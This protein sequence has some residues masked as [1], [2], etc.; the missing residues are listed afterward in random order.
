MQSPKVRLRRWLMASL[1]VV[2]LI[3]ILAAPAQALIRPWNGQPISQG[4]G[5]TYGEAWPISP[6]DAGESAIASRQSAPLALMPYADIKA[7]LDQFKAEAAAAGVPSRM[8]YEVLGQSA[9][10][11]DIY[12]VVINAMETPDQVRD[13]NRWK[14]IRS[15]MLTSPAEAQELLAT[16]GNDVKMCAYQSHIHGNEYEAVDSNMQVIRDLTVTPRG[17]NPTVDKI[18]DNEIVVV[19]MDNNPDGR[20]NGTRGNPTGLDPNRDFFVQSQPEQ[21]IAVA[22]MHRWLPT[23]FIEGHGYYTPTLID[24]VTIPHNP[25]IEED[26]YQ[27]WNV[28]R[29]EQNRADFAADG[30]PGLT[31]IQSPIRDWN[32]TGGTSTRNYLV[33][34]APYT[35]AAGP[36]TIA[37]TSNGGASE[38]G[39]IVTITTSSAHNLAVG[40]TVTITGVGVA[41]YNGTWT[42]A[43]IVSSTKFT[44]TNP[45]SALAASGS[46]TVTPAILGAS[47]AGTTVTINTTTAN[48]LAVGNTVTI[49]GVSVAG[50]NGTWTVASIVS[51]TQFTYTNPTSGLANSGGGSVT[52][53]SVAPTATG[54]TESGNTVTIT[55]TASN[56][57]AQGYKVVISGVPEA[58]Y[59]GTFQVTSVIS[60]TQF[61][62]T[63]PTSGL[64]DS[65][66]G[67]VALPPQPN[68]AQSWDDWGPFYGQSY[69]ALLGG[70]DGSTVEMT[71][72][73][74]L[75]SKQAQYLAFYSSNSFWV[76]HKAAMMH[77]HLGNFIRGAVNAGPNPTAFD[78]DPVLSSRYYSDV[79]QNY[80]VPYPKAYIIP[81]ELLQRSDSEANNLVEWLLRNGILVTRASADFAWGGKT[82]QAGSYVVWMNQPLRGIAWNALSAG[83]DISGTKITT[84]YASPGAW[85]HGLCWGADV[86]EVPRGDDT[87][88]PATVLTSSPSTL[89]GGIRDGVA[90]PSDWYSVTLKGVHEYPAI[91]GLLKSGIDAQMAETQFVSTTAGTMP[92]GTLIFPASAKQAL[93]EAGQDGGLWFERNVGVTMPPTTKVSKVPRIAVLVT[94]TPTGQSETSCV[95]DSIFSYDLTGKQ[96]SVHRLVLES[97]WDYVA[98]QESTG[99]KGLN[100]SSISDPLADYDVIYTTLTAWPT[101]AY[102]VARQRLADFFA[103]GGGFM[104]QNVSSAGFLTGATPSA[105]VTGTLTRGS[106]S[107]YGGIALVNNVGSMT[108]PITGPEPSLDTLFLPSTVYWYSAMPD[109]AVVDQQYPSTIATIGTAN[110]FVAGLWNGRSSAANNGPVLFHG[111][112][113]QGSRYMFYN[114]NAFSR[115]DGQREWLYFV[116]AALWSNLTD[117]VSRDGGP[118]SQSVQYGGSD[119]IQPVSFSAGDANASGSAMSV[120]A[121]DLP[122]G[123][124]VTQTSN[125]GSTTPGAASWTVT[126]NVTAPV[127]S[128][129]VTLTVTDGGARPVGTLKL[130]FTVDP[131]EITVNATGHDK[132]YDGSLDA[133]VDLAGVGLVSGDEVTFQYTAAT[134]D[135][136]DVGSDIPVVVQ[137]I[138]IHGADAGNYQL[139][140]DTAEARGSISPAALAITAGD[141]SKLFGVT[142]AFAG[143]EFTADGLVVGEAIDTVILTCDGSDAA[144]APGTY[145]IVPSAAQPHAGTTLGNYAV[146]YVNGTMTVTGGYQIAPFAKPL[147]QTDPRRFHRGSTIRVAFKVKD[148]DGKLVTT[149]GPT[150]Q[151]TRGG[152]VVL[153]PKTVKYNQTKKMYVYDVR[154]AKSWKLASYS[155]KVTLAGSLGRTVSFKLIK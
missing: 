4:L 23:A 120:S 76:D 66:G 10:G 85:S 22:Y 46:G 45:T 90:A 116:Q 7:L 149:V 129:P 97:D 106:G 72:S 51:S 105:L 136:A 1:F 113:T 110:G 13:F 25:G 44:Y 8:T 65:G 21:K 107:A 74:R 78:S 112:T 55:T 134:Y 139:Q 54:A 121:P 16:Y 31:S 93:D 71:S 103:R 99:P 28:Q 150:I 69:S 128:Y 5:P 14:T 111:N 41:A 24:G 138:S 100:N 19:L 119:A 91:R 40:N 18:L 43:S 83:V 79:W 133:T 47:E 68:L 137:G 26:T 12:G 50:Y 87:F 109:G 67:N 56:I 114:T 102:P 131:K 39:N 132:T 3:L 62:Y 84:L 118:A 130:T 49:S 58:G 73:N 80:F 154:T 124:A 30:V 61:T 146:T 147:R 125:N 2:L 52:S 60:P 96:Q 20:A 9:E 15:M 140:T 94:A 59:N 29:I 34:G 148:W 82:Y 108:S 63:N 95:L 57:L 141:Q 101:T 77:D 117:E 104:T 89:V 88:A 122:A 127:G 143:T 32:E 70:P 155:I 35:I 36:S 81:W 145:P 92:A 37:S 64:A 151:L 135:D 75:L 27:H 126:G 144:K 33:V 123:L 98:T 142:F 38:V 48:A 153:G 17:V 53:P 152:N 115:A 86:V 42:V 6:T 11:R